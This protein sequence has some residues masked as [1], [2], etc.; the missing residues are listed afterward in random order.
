MRAGGTS[1]IAP[2]TSRSS[3][4]GLREYRTLL[5]RMRS[6]GCRLTGVGNAAFSPDAHEP[7]PSSLSSATGNNRGDVICQTED[8]AVIGVCR[9][10]CDDC[11]GFAKPISDS[12]AP[13]RSCRFSQARR[14]PRT[15]RWQAALLRRRFHYAGQA[16]R[17]GG[18]HVNGET[19][20]KVRQ[21]LPH[22]DQK[23]LQ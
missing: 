2:F 21:K 10:S 23:V 1:S 7:E 13:P 8:V 11:T 18:A 6:C 14:R 16:P 12:G 20:E 17:E 5:V 19:A 3:P 9:T 15:P 22:S 4:G